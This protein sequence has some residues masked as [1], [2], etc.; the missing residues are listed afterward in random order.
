MSHLHA[1]ECAFDKY[2]L[3][4]CF[5]FLSRYFVVVIILFA[6]WTLEQ[7]VE[8]TGT[9]ILLIFLLLWLLELLLLLL[10]LLFLL[11][12]FAVLAVDI[13][14]LIITVIICISLFRIRMAE[15]FEPIHR[16]MHYVYICNNSYLALLSLLLYFFHIYGIYWH[17]FDQHIALL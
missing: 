14:D 7:L 10:V 9:Q 6:H 2:E 17:V 16:I 12:V 13:W 4:I 3:A 1:Y 8:Q 15:V 11:L 5:F